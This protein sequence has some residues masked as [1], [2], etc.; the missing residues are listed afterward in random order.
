M[1]NEQNL[2]PQA[3]TLTVEELS[4]GGKKSGESRRKKRT[5]RELMELYGEAIVSGDRDITNDMAVVIAQYDQ[6]KKGNVQAATF[7]R[8]TKGE[9]PHDVLETP[10]IE[11]KPLVDLSKRKKNGK[12]KQ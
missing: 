7:I 4:R 5:L 12:G 3:H 10:N 6:A 8:D 2:K 9:R 11:Y 1:A